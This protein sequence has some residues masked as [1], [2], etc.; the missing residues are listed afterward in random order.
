MME[1]LLSV[2]GFGLLLSSAFSRL[3]VTCSVWI[4]TMLILAGLYTPSQVLRFVE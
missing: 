2:V 4:K 1:M 3:D